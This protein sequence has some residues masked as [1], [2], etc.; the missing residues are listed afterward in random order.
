MSLNQ[1]KEGIAIQKPPNAPNFRDIRPARRLRWGEGPAKIGTIFAGFRRQTKGAR[2]LR[3]LVPGSAVSW[4][5]LPCGWIG[6]LSY[7]LTAL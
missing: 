4:I 1:R 5:V 3:L 7:L 6:L 2:A